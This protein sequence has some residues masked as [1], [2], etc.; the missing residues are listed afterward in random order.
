MLPYYYVP[1]NKS[2][3]ANVCTNV[4]SQEASGLAVELRWPSRPSAHVVHRLE[5]TLKSTSAARPGGLDPPEERDV[6]ASL[7]STQT[8]PETPVG[9]PS[10]GR[11]SWR[12]AVK[13]CTP[14]KTRKKENPRPDRATGQQRRLTRCFSL[15]SQA[16][17]RP[18]F[19]DAATPADTTPAPTPAQNLPPSGSLPP[20]RPSR[21]SALVARRR[22]G[23]P[24]PASVPATAR[25]L[26][27]S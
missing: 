11:A 27:P 22:Q 4:G 15:R 6:T 19:E 9:L 10:E 8:L 12:P 16:S 20:C 18:P 17:S 1:C 7:D 25:P 26:E 14:T 24:R 5:T 3:T 2:V 23:P 21:D 13:H